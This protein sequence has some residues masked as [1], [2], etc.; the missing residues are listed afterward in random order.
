MNRRFFF[1]RLLGAGAV[2]T[3]PVV[4]FNPERPLI[5]VAPYCPKCGL[6]VM[7][8]NR[9]RPVDHTPGAL[10]PVACVAADCGWTGQSPFAV[11]LP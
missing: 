2:G 11:P 7:F 10:N 4:T 5:G 8:D 1:T 3:V 9:E 6:A